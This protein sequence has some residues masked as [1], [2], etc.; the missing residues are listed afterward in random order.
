MSRPVRGPRLAGAL[1][2]AWA[3]AIVLAVAAPAAAREV[4]FLSGRV[5]D[6][7]EIL[8]PQAEQ[9][10]DTRL[11]QLEG[12]TGA[13]VVVLTVPSLEGDPLEDYALRVADTWK[14]G[15]AERDDGVLMLI[16]RDDRQ[17]R[18]EVGYGLEG[19]I[20]DILAGRI[21][22]QAVR[23]RFR[24]GDFDAGVAAGVD[25]VAA[26][27]RG[28]QPEAVLPE[29]ASRGVPIAGCLP[30]L[31][32]IFLI[33]LLPMLLGRK[34]RRFRVFGLPIV[35]GGFSGG[36]SRGGWGGGGGGF[37]GGGGSFGGGGASSSW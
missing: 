30:A 10:L 26:L 12:Q 18:L 15:G 5:V 4:P 17:M 34:R 13:Q 33:F 36:G 35:V 9:S 32:W 8:S 20:P 14:L 2:L 21:L 27:I 28:E 22:D 3:L 7:A 31:V 11:E 19:T 37:S 16:A 6:E 29:P 24:E 23:P 25:K 1:V